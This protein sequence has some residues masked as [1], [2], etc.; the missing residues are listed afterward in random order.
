MCVSLS[1]QINENGWKKNSFFFKIDN[2]VPNADQYIRFPKWYQDIKITK[3]LQKESDLKF[4]NASLKDAA[5]SVTSG[6]FSLSKV[7]P[8]K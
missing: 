8:L 1:K 3:N 5:L 2:L 6:S 4:S 7:I